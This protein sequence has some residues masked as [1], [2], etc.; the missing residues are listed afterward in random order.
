M[1]I[2]I[3]ILMSLALVGFIFQSCGSSNLDATSKIQEVTG[4]TPAMFLPRNTLLRTAKEITLR[5]RVTLT[6]LVEKES[7]HDSFGLNLWLVHPNSED[8]RVINTDTRLKVYEGLSENGESMILK[9]RT[10]GGFEF[11]ISGYIWTPEHKWRS[12]TVDE[13]VATGFFTIEFIPKPIPVN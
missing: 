5:P 10:D 7:G 11:E 13:L 3:C 8:E 2:K 12:P 6:N 1:K 4:N 9:V